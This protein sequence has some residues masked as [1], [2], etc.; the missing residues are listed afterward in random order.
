MFV[1]CEILFFGK[2]IAYLSSVNPQLPF[3]LSVEN[4]D[5]R[6]L[7]ISSKIKGPPVVSQ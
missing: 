6:D 5:F 3:V 1:G 2:E 7:V 4:D